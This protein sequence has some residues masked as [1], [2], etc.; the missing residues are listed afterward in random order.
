MGILSDLTTSLQPVSDT[1]ADT[2][3]HGELADTGEITQS[4]RL[5]LNSTDVAESDPTGVD[6][7]VLSF[8]STDGVQ[9]GL[10][11]VGLLPQASGSWSLTDVDIL[12][13]SYGADALAAVDIGPDIAGAPIVD[14]QILMTPEQ[15]FSV[16]VLGEPILDPVSGI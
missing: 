8:R 10:V 14:A 3:S 15:P 16:E 12:S 4:T 5:P 1:G 2:L 13:G 9:S 11:E 6:A 7:D